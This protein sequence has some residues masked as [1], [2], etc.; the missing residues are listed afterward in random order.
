MSW[1]ELIRTANWERKTVFASPHQM[2]RVRRDIRI[3]ELK[4]TIALEILSPIETD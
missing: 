1:R 3:Q 2:E 4:K